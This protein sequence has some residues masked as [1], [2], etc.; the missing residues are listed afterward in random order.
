MIGRASNRF[1]ISSTEILSLPVLNFTGRIKLVK[2]PSQSSGDEIRELLGLTDAVSK[3]QAVVGFDTEAKPKALY[4]RTRNATALIQLASENVCVLVRT[5]GHNTLPNYMLDIMGDSSI[6]KV[7]QGLGADIDDMKSDFSNFKSAIGL[8]DLHRIASKLGCYPKSL[9]GLVGIFLRKRLLKDMRVS[10]WESDVLRAE[11]I[12][13]AAIDAWAARAVYLEMLNQDIKVSEGNIASS[14]RTEPVFESPQ[15]IQLS[16]ADAK[17]SVCT[18]PQVQLVD[19]CLQRG[20]LLRLCGFE[21][22]TGEDKFK[23]SFEIVRGKGDVVICESRMYHTS[24]RAAQEDAAKVALDRLML[25][26]SVS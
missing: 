2:E 23:C 3:S 14:P 5:V 12:Q 10:N 4:S 17:G 15:P 21:K 26:S 6:V 19:H 22:Q 8:V 18:S 13:Y 20:Y 7:G 1:V 25:D 16:V 11:Q 24:I 9:Q